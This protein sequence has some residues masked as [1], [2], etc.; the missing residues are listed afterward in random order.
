MAQKVQVVLT[1]DLDEGPA[2]ETVSFAYDGQTYEFELCQAHLEEYHREMTR[3]SSAARPTAGRRRPATRP[4]RGRA[5]GNPSEI[6]VI[7]EWARNHGFEVNE[8]GRIP[9]TVREA[10]EAAQR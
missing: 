3:W 2:V 9:A 4:A 8:R 7:R 6:G 1:C 5:A 10:F